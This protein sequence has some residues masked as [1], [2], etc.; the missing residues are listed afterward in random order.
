MISSI[1]A[2]T[3][4]PIRTAEGDGQADFVVVG[5]GTAGAVLAARLSEDARHRVVLI[6]AGIDTPPGAVP[7]DIRDTFPSSTLNP[8]Y[9]WP[10]LEATIVK[11]GASRPFPQAKVMG[12]GS[13]IMGMFALRGVPSDFSRWAACGAEG[14][15]WEEAVRLYRKVESDP[16]RP[17]SV[18]GSSPIR[19]M[20]STEWPPF[21]SAM[22]TAAE[23]LGLAHIDD[24]NEGPQDGFFAMPVSRDANTRSTS[25]GCYLTTAVRSRKNLTILTGAR[26]TRLLFNGRK[27]VGVEVEQGGAV[28]N[29]SARRV[30]VSAGAIHSPTLLMRS[31]VG[32]AKELGALGIKPVVDLPGVG[33]NL[34]NHSYLFF[35]LT[36]PRGKR[37]AQH[38][39]RFVITGV[40]A[41]SGMPDCPQSDLLLFTLGRVSPRSFGTTVAM[42]GSALYS[43]FSKGSISLN[44]TNLDANPKIDFR[45][46]DDPR[47]APRVVKGA[48]LLE[49]LLR[50]PSVMDCYCEA[51]LLPAAMAVNQFNKGGLAGAAMAIGAQFV[52]NS[53]GPVRRMAVRKA[54]NVR[55]PLSKRSGATRIS[56]EEILASIAPMGHPVGT[57]AMG[58]QEDPR[59]VVDSGY[60]VVGLENVYVVD[61]SVMPVIP[62]ANTNLPTLMVAEH[63]A[64]KLLL[65][66]L[67]GTAR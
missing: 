52:L 18:S 9:F 34:Q 33:K 5:A 61:A 19:R 43:P 25:A 66:T 46:L 12:G 30:I 37:L 13:S 20:D 40:R 44:S 41:S 3:S 22:K 2:A 14:W 24:I 62:S 67:D 15:S 60:R 6:E 17:G 7:A 42:A 49:T 50:E 47:D 63:A 39:R 4:A 57:C 28:R 23:G 64:E 32:A 26:A 36:L 21:V 11:G 45:M 65:T 38:L 35:A 31:G 29:L 8:A 10:G 48:R 27:A 16:A 54:L 55:E 51:F 56:D 58:A 1:K 53:P 59:T